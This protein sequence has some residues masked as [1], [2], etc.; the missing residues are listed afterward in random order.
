MNQ[1]L[2]TYNYTPCEATPDHRSPTEI[3]FGRK[4]RTP[5]DIFTLT[6][7]PKSILSH[8]QSKMKKQFDTH[9][10]ARARRFVPGQQVLVQLSDGR[11]VSGKIVNIIGFTIAH[12]RVDIGLI[13]R[14]FNQT[15][16]RTV[17]PSE[18]TDG[19]AEDLLPMVR[20]PTADPPPFQLSFE[21]ANF[22]SNVDPPAQAQEEPVVRRSSR[23][24]GHARPD[25]RK[26]AGFRPYGK[27]SV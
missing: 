13:K 17:S 21:G 6:E 9:H 7:K 19:S 8:Q 22:S 4:F 11:R 23:F 3:F 20:N 16:N 14:H 26:L 1:F 24:A 18:R 15:W 12:V 5:L 25:Y 27:H 2:Y 10:G